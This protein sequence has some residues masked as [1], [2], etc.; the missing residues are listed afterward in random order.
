MNP[1]PVWACAQDSSSGSAGLSTPGSPRRQ[2]TAVVSLDQET[3]T[4]RWYR[5]LSSEAAC[6][7]ARSE[8]PSKRKDRFA[9]KSFLASPDGEYIVVRLVPRSI[10]ESARRGDDVTD[11]SRTLVV[12]SAETREVVR[13]VETG[14]RVLGQALTNDALVVETSPTF[15]LG[16]GTMTSYSLTDPKSDPFGWPAT[17]CSWARPRTAP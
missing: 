10:E 7:Y 16:G 4:V 1:R 8:D 15:H 9:A 13:T 14:E 3:G 2:S 6:S 17:G 11:Q 5:V 12:L